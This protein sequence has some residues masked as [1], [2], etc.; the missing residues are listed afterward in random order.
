MTGPNRD[1]GMSDPWEYKD[2]P[3]D[4]GDARK[5]VTLLDSGM[6]WVGIR[7]WSSVHSRWFNG[8]EPEPVRVLAWMDLPEPARKRWSRGQLV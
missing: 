5:F 8:N 1:G 6:C 4:D 2:N 3:P 7:V